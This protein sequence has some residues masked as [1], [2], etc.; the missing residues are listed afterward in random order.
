[1]KDYYVEQF[2]PSFSQNDSED[3]HDS[4]KHVV[5][6]SDSV[7]EFCQGIKV[8]WTGVSQITTYN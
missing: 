6:V 5:E 3:S 4:R 7:V 1:M 2:D 8:H